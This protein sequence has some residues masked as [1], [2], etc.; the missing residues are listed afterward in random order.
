M[1]TTFPGECAGLPNDA[2]FDAC[3]DRLAEC[4]ACRI[5]VAVDAPFVDCD[6]FD[7]GLAN[8]TCPRD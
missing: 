8:R 2:T 3:A 4:R 5:I 1:A 7:D 6:T